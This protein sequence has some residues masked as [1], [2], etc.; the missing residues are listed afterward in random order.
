MKIIQ[1]LGELDEHGTGRYIIELNKA[2]KMIGHDVEIVYFE[3]SFDDDKLFVQKIPNVTCMKY[4][5]ELLNKLNSADMVFINIMIHVKAKEQSRKEFY[6]IVNR[7]DNPTV[8]AFN[9][10]HGLPRWQVYYNEFTGGEDKLDLLR[11]IDKFVTFSP[12][13]KL[14]QKLKKIYPE[15]DK[16]FVHLQHPYSFSETNNFVDF[17]NKYRRVTYMGR[18]ASF[19]DPS[20]ILRHRSH[21]IDNNYQL[22]MRGM[23]RT[24]TMA[25]VP[26]MV[27]VDFNA[28]PRVKSPFVLELLTQKNINEY[29]P[30]ESKNDPDLIHLKDR[31]IDKI[32]LFGRYKREKGMEAMSHS[33]F[34]CNFIYFKNHLMFGDNVEYTVAEMI[35]M[36]TIPLLNYELMSNC[37]LYDK[38]GNVTDKIATDYPCGI[39][40]NREGE[41]AA[42]AVE[43][44]NKLANDKKAYD[45]YRHECLAFYKE[46]FNP[47]KVAS[48]LIKDIM[49]PD[50]SHILARFNY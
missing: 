26:G 27:Y 17:D 48:K 49:N 41:N 33:L 1:F 32:Y 14:F 39:C 22:E 42:E 50:N 15:I 45:K 4:G 2:L 19:K 23:V 38:D 35:D 25:T 20:Y 9:N 36:G 46:L 7:I 24:F 10:E 43:Q 21:F 29:Y 30:D 47:A 13:N 6:D 18:F 16:K 11:R 12:Y 37:R 3:N 34:G 44:M 31:D 5:D 28:K 8:V 40:F